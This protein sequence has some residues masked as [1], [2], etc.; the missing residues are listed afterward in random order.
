MRKL[1]ALIMVLGAVLIWSLSFPLIK[2]ALNDVP[3]IL[4]GALR[5]LIFIP[6][7]LFVFARNGRRIFVQSKQSWLVFIGIAAFAIALPNIFQN[8]GMLYTTATTSSIIQSTGPIFTLLLAVVFL[9]ESFKV[10]KGLG[11]AIAFIGTVILVTQGNFQFTFELYGNV[12]LL[13]STLS[14][15]IASI[16]T[17]KGLEQHEP[18]TLLTFVVFL[19][20]FLNLI[21]GIIAENV[22][23]LTTVSLTSWLV[24]VTLAV[25]PSFIGAWLWYKV[26]VDLEVSKLVIFLYLMPVFTFLF[27][28]I[29][30]HEVVSLVTVTAA[31]ITISGVALAQR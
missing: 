15:S 3:P 24:V 14:Y 8:I 17:K 10:T 29:T 13:L 28:F 22:W 19:G 30:I 4:L 18:L 27:S 5:N 20:F 21:P 25:F 16:I 31:V 2:I 23:S 7:L 12:L 1:Q 6:L 11:T 9:K 26:M